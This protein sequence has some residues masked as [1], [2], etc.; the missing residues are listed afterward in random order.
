[1]PTRAHKYGCTCST[2]E[3][4]VFYDTEPLVHEDAR[5]E[6]ELARAYALSTNIGTPRELPV[7]DVHADVFRTATGQTG[8][9]AYIFEATAIANEQREL[10]E[11]LRTLLQAAHAE[12]PALFGHSTDWHPQ[13]L[14]RQADAAELVTYLERARP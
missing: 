10:R 6:E 12:Q 7:V 2:C 1:M 3:P 9:D 14:G 11:R 8:Y 5:H 13:L 4:P